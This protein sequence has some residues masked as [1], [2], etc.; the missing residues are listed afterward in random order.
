MTA[1]CWTVSA[2]AFEAAGKRAGSLSVNLIKLLMAIALLGL[3]SLVSRGRPLPT[4]ATPQVWLWLSLSGLVGFVLGDIC[5]FQAFVV[6]GSRITML[7]FAL[8]PVF[9]AFFGRV[10]IGEVLTAANILGMAVTLSGIGLVVLERNAETRAIGFARPAGGILLAV[11]AAVGQAGGLVLSKHGMEV[12]GG[13]GYDPFSATQIRAVAGTA[14]F[15]LLFTLLGKWRDVLRALQDTKA[16]GFTGVGAFFGPFIGVSLS[17][18]AVTHTET[19]V[20]ATIM[21]LV[22]VLIIPPAVIFFRERVTPKEFLGAC[23]AVAGTAVL[24]L[25]D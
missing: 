7:V 13:G 5:L 17:L 9:G 15:I 25:F 19:G 6:I 20:A 8:V 24:F 12:F 3:F 23:V 4:D 2:Q 11:G 18:L 10:F 14:G 1:L 16:I 21:T 22:P